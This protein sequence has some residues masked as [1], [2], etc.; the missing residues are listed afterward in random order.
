M[1]LRTWV[2]PLAAALAFPAMLAAQEGR[3]REGWLGLLFAWEQDDAREARVNQVVEGSPA[4]AA[5]VRQGDVVV[6]ID[7]D[8]ATQ[9]RVEQMRGHLHVG[10]RV[11]LR[12]RRG[13]REETRTVTAGERPEDG[14]LSVLRGN[15]QR[16]MPMDGQRGVIIR[17]DSVIELRLDSLMTRMDSLRT[18]LRTL[19][20]DS[21]MTVFRFRGDSMLP[22]EGFPMPDVERMEVF[23]DQLGPESPFFMELGRR[24]VAGAELAEMNEG[25]G[26]YFR[27]DE[28]LLVLRV[29]PSTP[30]SR[31]GLEPGDVIVEVNGEA[32]EDVDDLRGAFRGGEGRIRLTVMREG[33]RRELELQW[34][35]PEAQP[36]VEYHYR[37]RTR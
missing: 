12:I 20:P 16:L 19:S 22:M 27:T 13:G 15:L 33:R 32:V 30:A 36:R 1:K 23:R 17:G 28:G 7:G 35:R 9:E 6:A 4:Y 25:L 29:S 34:D 21:G 10:T 24:T 26:R 37:Q 31:A 8:P 2:L 11:E 3:G 14:D 5:G 18:H